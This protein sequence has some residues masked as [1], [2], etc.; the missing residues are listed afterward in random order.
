MD[1]KLQTVI[2]ALVLVSGIVLGR[3]MIP[4]LRRIKTGK[5][6]IYIGDRFKQDGSEPRGGGA[7]I[8][9]SVVLG[10]FTGAAVCSL[11]N[12]Q[13]RAVLL[14]VLYLVILT[15]YGLAEDVQRDTKTGIGFRTGYRVLFKAV[16][17]GVYVLLL[18]QCGFECREIL[19]PFRWGY[20]SLGAAYVPVMALIMALLMTCW[21]IHD[22]HKGIHE[23]G[24]DGLCVMSA[25]VGMLGLAAAFSGDS[26]LVTRVLCFAAAGGCGALLVWTISPSKLY[27][28]QSGGLLIGGA[29][30]A[31][32]V[33]SG[34]H[35]TVLMCMSAA[36]IDSAC[37]GLQRAVFRKNKKLLL[38]GASLHEHM[39]AKDSGDYK[40]MTV[41]AVM[42][43][44]GVIGGVAFAV[45]ESKL[46][47]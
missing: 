43:I 17:S 20:I 18:G 7:V 25:A 23:T 22:C 9:L 37:A 24:I 16:L 12:V 30:C 27:L 34:L 8:L 10:I 28:G 4:V 47:I 2:L 41:F 36:I 5:F 14:T 29:F 35:L 15:G 45:Y 26:R 46:V 44:L 13:L 42:Q 31:A 33:L 38:K 32:M 11:D 3:V 21:E 40:I 19:L 6:E 39:K 1:H